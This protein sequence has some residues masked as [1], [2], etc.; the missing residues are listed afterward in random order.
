MYFEPKPGRP[1]AGFLPGLPHTGLQTGTS[2]T[3]AP[4]LHKLTNS[5]CKFALS[6]HKVTNCLFHNSLPF[7]AIQ[8]APGCGGVAAKARCPLCIWFCSPL[9]TRHSPLLSK[10][11]EL[12]HIE[13]HSYAKVPGEGYPKRS[14]GESRRPTPRSSIRR[15]LLANTPPF[16]PTSA[17]RFRPR[18]AHASCT[19]T[20]LHSLNLSQP[21]PSREAQLYQMRWLLRCPNLKEDACI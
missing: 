1:L 7:I 21:T 5:L 10:S 8:T 13:S 15:S 19:L 18:F 17:L 11:D 16:G 20:L 9:A 14:P 12:T 4:Y 2:S 3:F 6:F